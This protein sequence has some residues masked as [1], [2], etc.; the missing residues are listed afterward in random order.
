MT[1]LTFQWM[2]LRTL[3][4]GYL[5]ERNFFVHRRAWLLMLTGLLEPLFYLL[6]LGVGVGA[7]IGE[8]TVGDRSFPY[9]TY[10]APAVFASAAMTAAISETTFNV[11]GK[12]KFAKI[13]DGI[14]A[15]PM[16]PM[17]IALGEGLWALIRGVIYLIAFVAVMALLGM[18]DSAWALLAIPAGILLGAAFVGIGLTLS[19]FFKSWTD[20]DWVMALVFVMFFFSGTFAPIDNYPVVL[21]WVVY[22][23]PL[24][25]GIELTRGVMLA[26]PSW[27]MLINVAYLALV[28]VIGLA[29]ASKRMARLLY[30]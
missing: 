27:T 5:V 28:C 3:R 11:F 10:V 4:P 30:K 22:L 18:V 7:L 2:R 12:L 14:T 26:M 29:I 16:R 1:T 13:Y 19:T 21:Q 24:Y 25:H 20:F 23:S 17:D 6:G 8:I 9:A 15:T